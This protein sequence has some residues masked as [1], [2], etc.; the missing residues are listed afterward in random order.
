MS[1]IYK[2][3][4]SE[5]VCDLDEIKS[6]MKNR[7]RI[8]LI[9]EM[10]RVSGMGLKEAKDTVETY[11]SE[12]IGYDD[13][14]L[15]D[16]F[17]GYLEITHVLTKEEFMNIIEDAIDKM[18]VFHYTNMLDAVTSLCANITK[19]GGLNKIA[20]ERDKFLRAI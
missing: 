4:N 3:I 18:D 9:K 2:V 5:E 12:S 10:R 7:L 8:A 11:Y 16:A 13:E 17:R 6:L 20:E 1:E 15:L 14:G 19:K